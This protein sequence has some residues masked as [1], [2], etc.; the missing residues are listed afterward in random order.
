MSVQQ[1]CLRWNNHQPNFISVCSSLLH[2]GTLVDV[3]LAAEG[4]QL[5]AHKIVLS[6]CSSYFQTLF[7]TNPCQHPIV[8]LKDVQ[9]DDLKTMVDFMYYGEVN[10]SQEQ[11]PHILKTAEMLKI[12]GLAEMPTD[13][14]TL[15][16]SDSKSS[17]D[18]PDQLQSSGT[19]SLW[20]SSE[21]QFQQQQPQ[22]HHHHHHHQQSQ[23]QQMH[24]LR[25]S[26]SPLGTGTSPATRRKRLRKSSNNG[27]GDRITDDHSGVDAGGNINLS[28]MGQMSFGGNPSGLGHTLHTKIIKE[29]TS[30]DVD[31]HQQDSSPDSLDDGNGHPHTMQ[32]KPETDLNVPQ[33]LPLDISGGTTPSEHDGPNASCS[34][35][36]H[37]GTPPAPNP[38]ASAAQAL[39]VMGSKR[40]RFLIRQP[41]VKRDSDANNQIS[42]ETSAL[43]FDPFSGTVTSSSPSL[44]L[45]VP[46]R[47][48][49]HASE[50]AP[51]C[52]PSSPHLLSVPQS[53]PF[54]VKQHSHPLLP[55]QQSHMGLSST[56]SSFALGL[57]RQHSHPLSSTLSGHISVSDAIYPHVVTTSSS[58]GYI[59]TG[60]PM[61]PSATA[62]STLTPINSAHLVTQ[63][64]Q[65][66]IASS[67]STV[68]QEAENSSHSKSSSG[69]HMTTP[70]HSSSVILI[71][72]PPS[73]ISTSTSSAP[74][75]S[76][77]GSSSFE[78]MPTLRV[79]NEE[80]QRSVSS[81]QTNREIIT[82]ENPR[83]SHC[84]VIRPGPALGCNFCWNTIDGHG[85]ILRRKTKYHC[86]ECQT[87]LCIV[88]CFQEYHE[89]LSTENTSSSNNDNNKSYSSSTGGGSGSGSNQRH[90]SK[91]ESI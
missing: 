27:S 39:N 76:N 90:Y 45:T 77:L 4:R 73:P 48:E 10:V 79:K 15:T 68:K 29:S 88:P 19:D 61:L 69:Q 81:P 86:P 9:Y 80:L 31:S 44:L 21:S 52:V 64:Q 67:S 34:Q 65:Q 6:A 8:I 30:V 78:H 66:P 3:T 47:I 46:P 28:Q 25:R 82:L 17:S 51:S 13:A 40:N 54:L 59:I 26:P 83:S 49:R 14:A 20:G 24:Q 16:K 43:E 56:S 71:S 41:R 75:T 11:L 50:P 70:T 5:Q 84:P 35:S 32:I 2:N 18:Q 23:T 36:S 62:V 38:A 74:T 89:R 1:F 63:Q 37:S 87:N 22:P 42:P 55:S 91:T 7:T 12:K 33:T 72:E 60:S 53:T 58:S 85:R 57:H